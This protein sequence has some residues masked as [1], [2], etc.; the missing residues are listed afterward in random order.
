[1]T[2]IKRFYLFLLNNV[3]ALNAKWWIMKWCKWKYFFK[4]NTYILKTIFIHFFFYFW[5][6]FCDVYRI[7]VLMHIIF[8]YSDFFQNIDDIYLFLIFYMQNKANSK[9]VFNLYYLQ[10]T[11]RLRKRTFLMLILNRIRTADSQLSKTLVNK[12]FQL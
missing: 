10:S 9:Q 8:Y 12:Y 4:Y 7:Y 1:M 3:T 5:N 6:L 2:S 11:R